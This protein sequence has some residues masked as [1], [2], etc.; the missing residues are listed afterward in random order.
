MNTS[1]N[2]RYRETENRIMAAFMEL[3]SEKEPA[4]ISV[5]ELCERSG[6][7]RSSFYLHFQD[8]F[9][10]MDRTERHLA[11]EYGIIF[12]ADRSGFEAGYSL[13]DR[14]LE[15]FRYIYEHRRFYQVYWFRAKGLKVLDTALN[16]NDLVRMLQTAARYGFADEVTLGYHQLYFRSGMAALIGHWLSRECRETPEEL[17]QIL[18]DEYR[19]RTR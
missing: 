11:E 8:I 15:L 14:F 13:N 6:I 10:L 4:K 9:D 7:H 18:I 16:E 12:A 3:L 17:L 1:E 2:E 5:K 19:G